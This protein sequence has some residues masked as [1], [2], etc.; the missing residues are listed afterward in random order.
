MDRRDFLQRSHAPEPL[1]GTL[2]LNHLVLVP[3]GH[4]PCGAPYGYEMHNL[5]VM[6][7]PLRKWRF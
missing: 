1:H 6:A 5:N 2:A 3:K 4:H 7:S